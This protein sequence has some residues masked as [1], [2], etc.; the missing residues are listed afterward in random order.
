MSL[1]AQAKVLRVL[2]DG[3][4]TRI[5]GAK[6]VAGRRARAG[7]DEQGPGGGD[8]GRALS[9]GSLLPAER[10]AAPRA[11]AARAARGHPAARP[12]LRRPAVAAAKGRAGARPRR[13]RRSS[14]L[15]P[16]RVARQRAR[17]A[18][19]DRAAA[20]PRVGPADHG[21]RR[22]PAGRARAR[23]QRQ[24]RLARSTC[25]TFEEFKH[26]AERAF[27][28]AKLREYDWNV[29]ET[30]RALDMPRSNLYKKIE[31]YG[32]VPRNGLSA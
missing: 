21:R 4:V 8:R 17:A 10:R 2:Q 12:V 14:A 11:A 3:E 28:L 1:A 13:L 31:R 22:R 15:T 5:G 20:D 32:L 7:G 23:R 19:H 6:R 9:R 30:A 25:Q 18:Q 27:L 29:S 26:A 24:P 16:T